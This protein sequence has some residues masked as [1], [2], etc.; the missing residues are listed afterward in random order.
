MIRYI[1]A[2]LYY[3]IKKL[4]RKERWLIEKINFVND[5]TPALNAT[6]LN[7]LQQNVEDVTGDLSDL[8]TSDRDNLVEAINEAKRSGGDAVPIH[9]IFDY[10]GDTVPTGY[11]EVNSYSTNEVKT[12]DTWIDG[13]LIYRKVIDIGYLNSGD[14][15]IAHNISNINF[16]VD[17]KGF[18]YN[19]NNKTWFPIPRAYPTN[20]SQ[21]DVAVDIGTT[22]ITITCG[23][24]YNGA[25]F[26]GYII[27]E[28][29]KT[30]DGGNS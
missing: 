25:T 22:N 30:T 20:P 1:L 19:E 23:T 12:G 5:T 9:S 26:K 6:N 14:T 17:G 8:E 29:T 21:Y 2:K 4:F 7:K 11:E 24:N 10:D 16:I 18:F 28:Y 3:L 13:R 15:T 27:M